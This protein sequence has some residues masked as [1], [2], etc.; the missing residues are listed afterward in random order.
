ME[1]FRKF[2][3][4]LCLACG[5][6]CLG[7]AAACAANGGTSDDG[8]Q[9]PVTEQPQEPA[10]D[11]YRLTTSG[12]GVDFFFLDNMEGFN[13]GGTVKEGVTVR[14]T[15]SVGAGAT[16]TPVVSLN[17]Q[18]LTADADNVYSFVMQGESKLTASGVRMIRTITF[19]TTT[20]TEIEGQNYEQRLPVYFYDTDG[21]E[22]T[23]SVSVLDGDSFTFRVRVSS[24][25]KQDYVVLFGSEQLERESTD[26]SYVY[27]CTYDSVDSDTEI[28]VTNIEQDD[29]FLQRGEGTGTAA[30]PFLIKRPIDL[31][32]M[33]ALVNDS[34]YMG[35][36]SMAH[37]RLENDID[38]GGDQMYVT[39]DNSTATSVFCGTFDGNGKTISNFVLTDRVVDQESFQNE[40][41]PYV[42][43]FGYATATTT[44]PAVIKNLTLS[45]FTLETHAGE[46]EA[47]TYAGAIVGFGIGVQIT[48][49]R[50]ENGKVSA[51]G[52]D[53]QIICLG[54]I[55]GVLQAAYSV[56][57]T[58][59]IKYN[60]YIYGCSSDVLVEGVGSPRATGGIVGYLVSADIDAIAYVADCYATGDVIGGMHSGGI[61]GTLGMYSSVANCYATGEIVANNYISLSGLVEDYKVAYAGGIVGYAEG[62]TA[63]SSCYSGST[64][65]SAS[66]A[67]GTR[68]EATGNIV[69][70]KA[71]AG[72]VSINSAEAI[73][74]NCYDYN[75]TFDNSLF[76]ALG[77]GTREWTMS[78]AYPTLNAVSA[79]A[80]PMT[81]TVLNAQ[82]E[83]V[84]SSVREDAGAAYS[85]MSG[86]Y[87]SGELAE[88]ALS[89]GKMGWGYY[90]DPALTLKVPYGFV[91]VGDITLYTGFADYTQVAG[92]YY[93]DAAHAK[94]SD[95]DGR[96]TDF[97]PGSAYITLSADGSAFFRYGGMTYE[98]AY[99]YDGKTI[100]IYNIAI[101]SAVFTD[102]RTE[103]SAYAFRAT[104]EG[105]TLRLNALARLASADGS[106]VYSDVN[107]S[108][109][110]Y[111]QLAQFSYGT[112]KT[113]NGALYTFNKDGTG[114]RSSGTQSAAFTY[115][116]SGTAGN[117]SVTMS[118]SETVTVSGNVITAIGGRTASLLDEYSGTWSRNANSPRKFTFDG[119][120][121][122]TLNG[123]T[124]SYSDAG[125]RITFTIGDTPYEAYFDNG[126]LTINGETY[127]RA[128]GLTGT[129]FFRGKK[130]QADITFNG[131][132]TDG[133]GEA[134]IAYSGVGSSVE[135][136]GE[137]D[138]DG[139]YIRVYVGNTLYAELSLNAKGD[140]LRGVLY[141]EVAGGYGEATLYR[142]D[143][144]RGKWTTNDSRFDVIDFNGRGM[145]DKAETDTIFSVSGTVNARTSGNNNVS[146]TYTLTSPYSGTMVLGG[147]TYTIAFDEMTGKFTMTPQSAGGIDAARR[148]DWYGIVLYDE[149]GVSY[150]FDGKG[151]LEGTVTLS[152]GGTHEYIINEA[153]LPTID[154]T[155]VTAEEGYF[156]W[157]GKKLY[158]RTGFA[159]SWLA[160][161]NRQLTITEAGSDFMAT[162]QFDGKTYQF[163]YDPA[164]GNLTYTNGATIKRLGSNELA[165]QNLFTGADEYIG[166]IKADMADG[167]QGRTFTYGNESWSFDGLGKA[168][169]GARGTA[170]YTVNGTS[171]TYSYT[172]NSF[173]TPVIDDD[174]TKVFVLTSGE[175]FAETD[176]ATYAFVSPDA[177]YDVSANYSGE[178]SQ[179]QYYF[180]GGE[181]LYELKDGRYVAAYTY[182]VIATAEGEDRKV[183]LVSKEDAGRYVGTLSRLSGSSSYTLNIV[184]ESASEGQE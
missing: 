50:V 160:S 16:G 180:D 59:V 70:A 21:E 128:D 2:L 10:P 23:D 34:F 54:G 5:V 115:T 124:A 170:T 46:A 147:V 95:T 155:A 47:S 3:I 44:A 108:M 102:V 114:S 36:F 118:T 14:F 8:N 150:S 74:R 161:G 15:V 11:Y 165:I 12:E 98:S 48:G 43:M 176:G 81:I 38:M 146:G 82:G 9:P 56:A 148:D 119:L 92:T 45:D 142:Y 131:I 178:Q 139:A 71:A 60:T 166:G 28:S 107:V 4:A 24:Y 117:Y 132:G 129:W 167:W 35:V 78:G 120:G 73:V 183:S 182:E 125:D 103:G 64:V 41:L 140:E 31:F 55:A 177:M 100:K 53:S 93:I 99:T 26:E 172:V 62:D 13:N 159:G 79:A 184:A 175:G 168:L 174:G 143:C 91:P 149:D 52:D 65:L 90:F 145:Y 151:L 6:A 179:A 106:G 109:T 63:I 162:V 42:G 171:I 153:G 58:P 141:S 83:Q 67:S 86:W 51:I 134:V 32:N 111:R 61:A 126:V 69:A 105:D 18:P 49:C 96:I 19:K 94:T 39:G 133:Y 154:G 173:G 137:Y 127:S 40:F 97:V 144:F 72:S 104:L 136:Y 68:Y 156:A 122:V 7:G 77:W 33:A 85:T 75:T 22:I 20:I 84:S 29:S 181:T 25:Y 89:D 123:Q 88:Y 116:I 113:D 112:Y 110:A 164:T 135:L 80:R 130:E 138:V 121:T 76:T 30:D 27:E 152:E 17:G 1:K 87:S 101:L 169:Y 37:F 163:R 157:N 158:F 66:S 57:Y